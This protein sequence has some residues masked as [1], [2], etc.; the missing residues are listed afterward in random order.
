M[1]KR[2]RGLFH[3]I[4]ATRTFP[5]LVPGSHAVRRGNRAPNLERH[6]LEFSNARRRQ[7][8][9]CGFKGGRRLL[10]RLSKARPLKIGEYLQAGIRHPQPHNAIE[11][12]PAIAARR[13]LDAKFKP[14]IRPAGHA[15]FIAALGT[16]K[17]IRPAH[18]QFF[19]SY[20]PFLFCSLASSLFAR[21]RKFC[22]A[23]WHSAVSPSCTRQG[24]ISYSSL[25]TPR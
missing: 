3:E 11:E 6:P 23:E 13:R 8:I 9:H 15:G 12:Y 20:P 19:I 25:P 16:F 10:L 17:K 21:G 22:S 14:R 5:R 24:S 2:R 7:A 4:A 1:P 18:A